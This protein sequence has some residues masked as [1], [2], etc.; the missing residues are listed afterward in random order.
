VFVHVCI[1]RLG[2]TGYSSADDDDGGA[3]RGIHEREGGREVCV[4]C[5]LRHEEIAGVSLYRCFS[6]IF[7][8]FN[9]GR[10]TCVSFS[11]IMKFDRVD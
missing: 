10:W 1:C 8:F 7:I 6:V 4:F 2:I 5:A 9:G 3:W 11:I